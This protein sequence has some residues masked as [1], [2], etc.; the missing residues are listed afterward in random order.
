MNKSLKILFNKQECFIS[1]DAYNNPRLS[2]IFLYEDNKLTKVYLS[3]DG[4]PQT[5]IKSNINEG[6]AGY[7][8]YGGANT[9][10][11]NPSVSTGGRFYGRGFG[12]GSG[13]S[14]GGPNLMYTYEIKPL[15]PVLQQMPTP[16]GNK[17]YI[18]VGSHVKGFELNTKKKVLGKIIHV[19]ENANRNVLYY[20]IINANGVKQKVDPTSVTLI[21]YEQNPEASLR[22]IVDENFYPTIKDYLNEFERG[23]DPKVA[24][25]IGRVAKIRKCF[26]DLD[27]PDKDYTITPTE[28][29]FNNYLNLSDKNVTWLPDNLYINGNLYLENLLIIELPN[30]LEVHGNLWLGNSKITKLPNNLKVHD[31]LRLENTK[32]TELPNDVQIGL[33]IYVRPRQTQLIK[34]I[35]NSS[36]SDKL[37]I[38]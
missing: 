30:G 20:L 28:V 26:R 18:H 35:K 4:I 32:I 24:L 13:S 22:D 1:K 5:I 27:V 12:F 38:I 25:G 2:K 8:V 34:F 23:L 11:G 14:S 21:N 36:F 19:V 16:Q 15:T 37:R 3:P 31:N 6:G 10:Y 17:R 9:G 29:I 7:A 33:N